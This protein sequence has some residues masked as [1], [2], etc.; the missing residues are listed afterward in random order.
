MVAPVLAAL[1]V[2]YGGAKLISF[3]RSDAPEQLLANLEAQKQAVRLLGHIGVP[4]NLV[5]D[6]L[7]SAS[8]FLVSD[9]QKLKRFLKK[10]DVEAEKRF[11][12]RFDELKADKRIECVKLVLKQEKGVAANRSKKGSQSKSLHRPQGDPT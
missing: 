3:Y 12:V 11:S 9:Q 7:T 4:E 5:D 2:I 8:H 1:A 6:Q 10:C